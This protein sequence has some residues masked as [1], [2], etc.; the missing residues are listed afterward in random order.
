MRLQLKAHKPG[1]SPRKASE[2][3][4]LQ[5]FFKSQ[6]WPETFSSSLSSGV[7]ASVSWVMEQSSVSGKSYMTRKRH[8]I[9]LQ[10][11]S[12]VLFSL[13]VTKNVNVWVRVK[14]VQHKGSLFFLITGCITDRFLK[15]FAVQA[16]MKEIPCGVFLVSKQKLCLHSV[17]LTKKCI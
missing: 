10:S 8:F 11:T 5:M 7:I 17:L 12:L 13:N 4:T 1:P 16:S 6:Y 15:Y 14:N 3:V 2:H 9:Y